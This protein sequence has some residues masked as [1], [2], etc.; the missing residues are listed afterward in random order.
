[1]IQQINDNVYDCTE[2]TKDIHHKWK[3]NHIQFQWLYIYFLQIK[4]FIIFPCQSE[5]ALL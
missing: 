5:V 2:I 1:M 3:K 4:L